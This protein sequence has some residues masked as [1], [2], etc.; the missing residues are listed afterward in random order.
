[1]RWDLVSVAGTWGRAGKSA[2]RIAAR[3]TFPRDFIGFDG[4][5]P[6]RPVVPGFALIELVCEI[7]RAV[8]GPRELGQVIVAKFLRPVA[9]DEGVDV[10]IT[11]RENAEHDLVSAVL[12]VEGEPAATADLELTNP[13]DGAVP[14]RP[15]RP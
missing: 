9:P 8:T 2:G 10:T 11:V 7:T 14:Q 4:H 1:M 12:S 15:E 5:F 13:A 3:A 6:G